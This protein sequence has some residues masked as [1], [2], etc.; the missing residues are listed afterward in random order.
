MNV[1]YLNNLIC[2]NCRSALIKK[3]TE[4]HCLICKK[5]Y[6][7]VNGIPDFRKENKY[8]CNVNRN[9]MQELNRLAK[10]SGDWLGAARKILPQYASHFIPF[11]RADCQFLWPC[12][13]DSRILDAGSMWGGITIPA[14]QFHNEVYA[15]DKTEETLE[16][17]KTRAEQMGFDNIYT[18]ASG[19]QKLPF[20]NGFFDLVILSGVLEWV[21]CDEEIILERD[22][23]K[24]G[25]GLRPEKKV[26]YTENPKRVQIRVLQEMR[27]ILKP[28]GALYLAIEN[29]IGYLYLAGY[30]DAHMNLPFIS[31]MPR[32]VSNAIT[33]LILNCEYRTYVYTIPGYKS[34]LKQSGFKYTHFYA[35]FPHYI[36]PSEVVPLSLI[37]NL[38]EKIKSTKG[39]FN[40]IL[41]T[42]IPKSLLKWLS[43]SIIAI[44]F[45]EFSRN[46]P[47]LIQVLRKTGLLTNSFSS[48]RIAK[49]D[50]R[51]G[52]DLTANYWVYADNKDQPK[53]FCKI[54]R[55]RKSVEV[56]DTESKN[57]KTVDL[58]LK[59]TELSCNIP[60]LAY[61]GTIDD[62]TFMV[63]EYIDAR[64][65]IFAFNGRLKRRLKSLDKEIK[66]AIRFLASFQKQT[67]TRKVKAVP[68]LIS[69]LENNEKILEKQN[70]L[71]KDVVTSL[72]KL[73]KKINQFSGLT[74]PLCAQHGDYDL[75]HNVLFAE[76][77]IR[78]LDFEHFEREALPFL[79]LATL[80]FNPILLSC[81]YQNNNLPL[82]VLLDRYNLKTYYIDKWFDLYGKLSGIPKGLLQLVPALAAVEQK[83][84]KYPVYRNPETF[85]I[86]VAFKEFLRLGVNWGEASL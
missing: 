1:E 81:E 35:A 18:I 10:E 7:I 8:W 34:L 15:V 40:R 32:F 69:F 38:K 70:L 71:T 14:A 19:L 23:K 79:D 17:L 83:T 72:N 41:L 63:M 66:M 45:K 39:S 48:V 22:W 80:L 54:C 3:N 37:K 24:F 26:K 77:G 20:P 68:Y 4:L 9:K 11:E 12:T 56:L 73:K 65:S 67:I 62:I 33:K 59:G 27:R 74:I 50:S 53:Y 86:N 47:R 55:N 42:L 78:I 44:A 2:P 51:S 13:K 75:F 64:K 25:C 5:G 60:K 29:R 58:L 6:P 28:G 30:P 84:R 31:F 49:C 76:N 82:S 57:L 85:P 16:F 21:A 43:P 46:E 61:Y 52:N 36:K